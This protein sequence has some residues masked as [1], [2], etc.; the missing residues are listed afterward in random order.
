MAIQLKLSDDG[1]VVLNEESKPMVVDENGKEFA[2]DYNGLYSKIPS[3]NEEA[4]KHR[5]KAQEYEQKLKLFDGIEDLEAWK[6]QAQ[7]ALEKVQTLDQSQ[8]VAAGEVE[9]LKAEMEKAFVGKHQKALE[10]F[11]KAKQDY[12]AK[13]SEKDGLLYKMAIRSEFAKSPTISEKTV[14]PPDIA[15]VYFGKHFKVEVHNGEPIV[16]GYLPS[17]D[18][19]FSSERPGE[20]A[21]FE[22]AIQ[23]IISAY[24]LKD[25]ILKG[26]ASGS[27]STGGTGGTSLNWQAVDLSTLSPSE[28]YK[29][30]QEIGSDKWRK[31]VDMNAQRNPQ[32]PAQ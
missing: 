13:L 6:S 17:G 11:E 31:L 4:K 3:L 1:H 16:V 22:E 8:M 30:R 28:K 19:V 26:S 10:Q 5:L 2:L 21:D 25:R 15:E 23:A 18:M 29:L 27:G 14:L 32:F 9:K 20:P 12:E 24:P 7:E